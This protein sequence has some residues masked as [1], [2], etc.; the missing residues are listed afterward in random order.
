MPV[1]ST[2]RTPESKRFDCR[3]LSAPRIACQGVA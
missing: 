1:S 3:T 2:R